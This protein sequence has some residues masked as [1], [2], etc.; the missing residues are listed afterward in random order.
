MLR[1]RS[2]ALASGVAVIALGVVPTANA[3]VAQPAAAYSCSAGYFCIYSDWN[4]G[5]TRCQ[6]SDEKKANTAD[7]CS[8]I[9]GGKNVL[10][11]RNN[12]NHR[13]QYYTQTNYNARVGSTPSG[14][15]GNLQGNYQIRSFKKQ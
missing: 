8:F 2:L 13:V 9:Q 7:N 5:G 14:G 6:W 1:L 15:E 4:G 11:V 3:A 12:T 10:S